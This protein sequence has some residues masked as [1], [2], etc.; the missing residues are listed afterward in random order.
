MNSEYLHVNSSRWKIQMVL[1]WGRG[2]SPHPNQPHPLT[3][4]P[5]STHPGMGHTQLPGVFILQVSKI[6]K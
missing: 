1:L 4:Q 3:A 5:F 6:P 2:A